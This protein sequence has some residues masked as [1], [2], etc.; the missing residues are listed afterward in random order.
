[1]VEIV[2]LSL[3]DSLT[4]TMLAWV[5]CLVRAIVLA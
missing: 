4:M 5:G 1:M 2:R 3:S